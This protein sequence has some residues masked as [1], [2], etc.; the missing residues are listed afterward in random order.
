MAT[1]S[2]VPV[3]SGTP[4]SDPGSSSPGQS[5]QKPSTEAPSQTNIPEN[6]RGKT[7]EQLAEMYTNLEKKIGEQSSEV[8]T[9]RK[10]KQD[11][12]IVLQ[13]IWSDP[14]TYRKVE[15]KVAEL[16][17]GALPETRTPSGEGDGEAGKAPKKENS[18]VRIAEQNRAISEFETKFKLTELPTDKRSDLNKKIA[19]E[20]VELVDPGGKKSVSQVIAETPVHLLPKFL[21]K[22]YWLAQKDALLSGGTSLQDFASIGGIPSSSGKSESEDALT[23]HELKVAQSLRVD[24]KKYAQSKKNIRG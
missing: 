23:E 3:D 7:P 18:D 19:N 11:M 24:P 20:L 1:D 16:Q 5:Q 13:A 9:V 22:A 15:R 2:S 17:G 10:M 8:S 14:E 6:L 12:D 4:V 21:E